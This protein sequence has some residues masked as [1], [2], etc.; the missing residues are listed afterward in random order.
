MSCC[1]PTIIPFFGVPVSTINYGPSLVLQYGPVPKV[2]V[3]YWDGVQYVSAGITTQ[4]KFD[5]VP[6][7]VITVDHGG[8]A[9]GLI[10]IG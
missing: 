7:T 10:K 2:D 8:P 5:A 6:A 9:T 4:M 3:L 1:S